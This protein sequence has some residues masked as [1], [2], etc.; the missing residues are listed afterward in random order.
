MGLDLMYIEQCEQKLQNQAVK[1]VKLVHLLIDDVVNL[2]RPHHVGN[3][4]WMNIGV[5][6]PVVQKLSC[7]A[8]QYNLY[9]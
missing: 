9:I 1:L 8:L 2:E 5:P 3:K 6:D 7:R 4:L